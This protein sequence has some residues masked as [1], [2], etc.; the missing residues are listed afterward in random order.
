MS[1]E[2][3]SEADA[4][5]DTADTRIIDG[6]KEFRIQTN[7]GA[8]FLLRALVSNGGWY[9]GAKELSRRK[10][11]G[12]AIGKD[13]PPTDPVLH[14]AWEKEP[15]DFWLSDRLKEH[16]RKCVNFFLDKGS[17]SGSLDD[18]A[19]DDLLIELGIEMQDG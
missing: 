10:R 9:S 2:E 4:A 15:C 8:R 5:I 6:A 17:F 14:A 7:R 11:L 1:T 19:F 18:D 12:K 13:T 16:A 3:E